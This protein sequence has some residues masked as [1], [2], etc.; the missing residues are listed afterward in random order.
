M[1]C[2]LCGIQHRDRYG[3]RISMIASY[4]YDPF[5]YAIPI[6]A[7]EHRLRAGTHDAHYSAAWCGLCPPEWRNQR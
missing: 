3:N 7:H 5:D 4:G 6:E 2:Q 1:M